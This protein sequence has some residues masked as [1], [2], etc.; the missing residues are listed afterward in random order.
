MGNRVLLA[1]LLLLTLVATG[2][3]PEEVVECGVAPQW[4][5]EQIGGTCPAGPNDCVDSL[6]CIDGVCGRCQSNSDCRDG[7]ACDGGV[8]GSCASN[9]ECDDGQT[10]SWGYCAD[11]VLEWNL[12]IDPQDYQ[13]LLTHP[14]EDD[15]YA[16]VLT[17]GGVDYTE[18]CR[19]RSYGST[20]RTFPKL[21]FRITFPEDFDH[22]GYS[23]KITL[24]TEYNDQTFLRNRLGYQTFSWL[25]RIP[26]PRTRYVNLRVNG[27]IYG[28]MLELERPGGKWLR[29]NGRDRNQSMYEA[30]HSPRQGGLMP[31]PTLDMYDVI[32]DDIMYNKKS[33][34]EESGEPD[35]FTDLASLIELTLWEDFLDSP[36][37]SVTTLDR[38]AEAFDVNT[39]TS[40]LA[41]EALLQNRDHVTANYN[42]SYQRDS[43]GEPRWEV[44]PYDLDTSFGCVYNRGAGNN[45]CD[46]LEADLWWLNG[47]AP[48]EG[49]IGPTEPAWMNLAHHL[50]LGEP[51]CNSVF[52]E[53]LC[54]FA[55]GDFWNEELPRLIRSNADTIRD[56][57]ARAPQDRNEDIANFEAGVEDMLSFLPARACY[58][59]RSLGCEERIPGCSRD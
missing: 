33:G 40:Y 22:P 31:M 11:P 25:M 6:G 29:L 4:E 8:C 41:V 56:A 51:T 48:L 27:E 46:V 15:Y 52:Q 9:D 18:G 3:E 43:T 37:R 23:R 10:C 47:V 12:Q 35:D 28:L 26:V 2:C 49:P 39:F 55:A 50:P 57:V 1:L 53:R 58:L 24:R 16:C 13:E 30:E 14:F 44:Y 54:A 36:S 45:Y 19:I 17:A 59:N 7:L 32:D 38:T 34:P 42:I 21:S 5:F 20:A